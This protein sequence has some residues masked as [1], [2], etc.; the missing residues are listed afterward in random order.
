VSTVNPSVVDSI[1]TA[2][3]ALWASGIIPTIQ[4]LEVTTGVNADTIREATQELLKQG[5]IR[6]VPLDQ[7]ETAIKK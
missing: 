3:K 7:P 4:G 6:S 1:E 2:I 5:R